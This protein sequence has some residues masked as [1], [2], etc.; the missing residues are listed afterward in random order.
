MREVPDPSELAE[1]FGRDRPV[2]AY[3]LADL[4]PPF[5]DRSTWFRRGDAA[6]GIV[7]LGAD[8]TTV[9]AISSA[10][11]QGALELVV[12]LVDRIPDGA[13]ITGPVGLA[14]A[15]RA[16]CHIE[17]LGL[18]VKCVRR[19][20]ASLPSATDVEPLGVADFDR[21]SALHDTDPGAAF[22]LESMLA[23]D[24]FVGVAARGRLVAAAGTHT[25]SDRYGIAAIGGVLVDPAHRGRGLGAVVTAGVCNRIAGRVS[26]I[27]LN[28]DAA[29]AAAR[30]TYER[31]GFVDCLEYEEV[32]VN[33]ER[34][35]V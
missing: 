25:I 28:V 32:I 22:V 9:Y 23:T 6:V 15:T 30:R 12:D 4:E 16:V 13:M 31:L 27:C 18:H 34:S 21:L 3:G 35:G 8:V 2:H 10:D 29:N 33:P 20:G 1:L 14:S 26:T 5:W 17:D 19:D 7:P 24:T 11:P